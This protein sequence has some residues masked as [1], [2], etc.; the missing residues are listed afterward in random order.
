MDLNHHMK[1]KAKAMDVLQMLENGLPLPFSFDEFL[2]LALQDDPVDSN[3]PM[4]LLAL[5]TISRDEQERVQ[6]IEWDKNVFLTL[7]TVVMKHGPVT[8]Y[9]WKDLVQIVD[10]LSKRWCIFN[11]RHEET[12][13]F[14]RQVECAIAHVEVPAEDP[15]VHRVA[16]ILLDI[17]R[18]MIM[19]QQL[20]PV[21]GL[22]DPE[23]LRQFLISYAVET[24]QVRDSL[25]TGF[26]EKY[27][28]NRIPPGAL[29]RFCKERRGGERSALAVIAHSLGEKHAHSIGDV[30][31]DYDIDAILNTNEQC[32]DQGNKSDAVAVGIMAMQVLGHILANRR[33]VCL[34]NYVIYHNALANFLQKKCATVF[35]F[36]LIQTSSVQWGV[37]NAQER[38]VVEYESVFPALFYWIIQMKDHGEGTIQEACEWIYSQVR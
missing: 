6:A 1:A 23:N 5:S 10:R 24:P 3:V 21:D 12:V 26:R 13:M 16:W 32:D 28:V 25:I 7:R 9:S 8:D 30:A 17:H 33:R 20:N 18:D 34:E 14:V 4:F 11:P 19:Q 22:R 37:W 29:M 35:P 36:L 27:V 31:Y 38:H 15:S 2:Y